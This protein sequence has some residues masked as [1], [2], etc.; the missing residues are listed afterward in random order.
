M[1]IERK[2]K[3]EPKVDCDPHYYRRLNFRKRVMTTTTTMMMMMMAMMMAMMTTMMAIRGRT[4]G[5][6]GDRK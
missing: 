1:K 5:L 3:G 2:V 6:P 4:V